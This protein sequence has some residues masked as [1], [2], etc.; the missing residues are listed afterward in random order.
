MTELDIV[1]M[2]LAKLG[3]PLL[4]DGVYKAASGQPAQACALFFRQA[5]TTLLRRHP[6]SF[7][8]DLFQSKG[9][10]DGMGHWLHVMP[11]ECNRVLSVMEPG[12]VKVEHYSIAGRR[13]VCAREA[14]W[15]SFV[16]REPPLAFWDGLF[17]EC[18]VLRLA[19]Y[20][21]GAICQNPGLENQLISELE[22]V[23]FPR[24]ITADSR[25]V[26]SNE[27]HV[28]TGN[29]MSSLLLQARL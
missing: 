3:Q 18:V 11:E 12:G 29:L 9:E 8:I 1:N 27:N 10:Q 25:E 28:G 16:H 14:V 26:L 7:A 13:I 4:S 2:A 21:A 19:A 15:V 20:L 24:A 6:W 22:Q 5:A 17:T 23:V